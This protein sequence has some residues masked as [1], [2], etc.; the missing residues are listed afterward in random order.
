MPLAR[1]IGNPPLATPQGVQFSLADRSKII[2][3][4]ITHAGLEKLAHH[5]LTIEQF[6]R[7][8]HDHRH[9]IETAASDK[10]D[11]SPILRTPFVIAPPDL[12]AHRAR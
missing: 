2:R 5:D 6:E 4:V 7:T 10:Y 8:F 9:R 11:A 12:I 1:P 3:C